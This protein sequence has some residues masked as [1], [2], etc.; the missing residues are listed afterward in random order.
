MK[1]KQVLLHP[2]FRPAE[3]ITVGRVLAICAFSTSQANWP[4]QPRPNPFQQGQRQPPGPPPR[5]SG[6]PL[7]PLPPQSQGQPQTP[8]LQPGSNWNQG[9]QGSNWNQGNIGNQQDQG[10]QHTP[11]WQPAPFPPINNQQNNRSPAGGSNPSVGLPI[12]PGGQSPNQRPQTPSIQRPQI[13]PDPVFPP[14]SKILHQCRE[15][16]QLQTIV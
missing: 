2:Y 13:E 7:P 3:M 8:V 1:R 4:Q 9:N 11:G 5:R 10:T 6:G 12:F 14:V 16:F 15:R